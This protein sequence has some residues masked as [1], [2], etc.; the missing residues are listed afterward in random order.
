MT[1]RGRGGRPSALPG[2]LLAA[3]LLGACGGGE[4][5]RWPEIRPDVP[6]AV[7]E[8]D[9][10]RDAPLVPE[11]SPDA[12]SAA[13]RLEG[14][15]VAEPCGRRNYE[16]RLELRSGGAARLEERISPCPP[17]ARCVWS[18]VEVV[19]GRWSR[20][21]AAVLLELDDVS[22]PMAVDPPAR[23]AVTTRRGE[24]VLEEDG[25][26]RYRRVQGGADAPAADAGTPAA[27]EPAPLP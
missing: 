20:R 17:D 21:D 15:W 12:P 11:P 23:L 9:P 6:S 22:R 13:V 5:S 25:G 27:A 16:R 8:S 3:L 14:A 18:G 10:P 19:Q 4:P 24:V 7:T 2:L 26:C 1:A